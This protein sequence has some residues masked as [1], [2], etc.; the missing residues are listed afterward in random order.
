M[1]LV[2]E[3]DNFERG[4]TDGFTPRRLTKEFPCEL[5][6]VRIWHNS[7][8]E[9]PGWFLKV[10]PSSTERQA[11]LDSSLCHW[12]L[13][14]DGDD[15]LIHRILVPETELTTYEIRVVTR[16]IDN[17]GTDAN[18]YIWLFGAHGDSGERLLDIEGIN[19]FHRGKTDDFPSKKALGDLREVRIRHDNTGEQPGWFLESV[20]VRNHATGQ[21]WFF[22]CRRW[23]ARDAVDGRT[24]IRLFPMR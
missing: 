1:P 4:Q 18:V 17:A 12:W 3:R 14:L 5:K 8:G 22:P 9:K 19:N 20:T 15:G 16:D 24:D 21:S 11:R 2:N 7:T 6:E 23:L 13:A 10:S